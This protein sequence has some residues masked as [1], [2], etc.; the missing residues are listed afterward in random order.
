[1]KPDK[2][3]FIKET[4]VNNK[5]DVMD[6]LT[7]IGNEWSVFKTKAVKDLIKFKWES[8]TFNFHMVGFLNH[9]VLLILIAVYDV[10]V[11]LNDGLYEWKDKPESEN[12]VI[13][14]AEKED[15]KVRERIDP[16][17]NDF[18]FILLIGVVYSFVYLIFQMKRI[19]VW[20]IMCAP[21]KVDPFIWAEVVYIT[22][23][24]LVSLVHQ[25][26]DPQDFIAKILMLVQL[27]F[28]LLKTFK[29]LRIYELFSP[30][31]QMIMRVLWDLRNFT[32]MFG[33]NIMFFSIVLTILQNNKSPMYIYLPGYL[34][35]FFDSL[36]CS[37][38][39]FE[40]IKRF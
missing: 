40:V 25:T 16:H 34:G 15:C 12:C 24:I 35:N 22:I 18:A 36:R 6:Q 37:I 11:Y 33:V 26:Y 32:F 23:C 17:G 38:G 31:I 28:V 20:K 10:R 9:M 14:L 5:Y 8:Y 39:N 4:W 1:M 7:G 30:L 29:Y 27:V 13:N 2:D 21:H 19:G 3:G